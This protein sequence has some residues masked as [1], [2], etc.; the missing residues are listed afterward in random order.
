MANTGERSPQAQSGFS[1]NGASAIDSNE[2]T[3]ASMIQLNT[4]AVVFFVNDFDGD[5]IPASA[6]ITGIKVIIRAAYSSSFN[7][8]RLLSVQVSL[9]GVSGTYSSVSLQNQNITTS[10]VDY[11]FGADDDLWGLDWSGWTDLSDLAFKV[12]VDQQSAGAT[13]AITG[14]FEVDAIVYYSEAT[15]P[16]SRVEIQGS[17]KVLSGQITIK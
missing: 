13:V 1:S 17:V 11:D 9:D 14:I 7:S 8:T 6:T 16:K 3:Q 2:S 10:A 4:A 12:Q 5:D 15:L